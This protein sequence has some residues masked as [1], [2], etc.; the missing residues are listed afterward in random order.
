MVVNASKKLDEKAPEIM[1]LEY[2]SETQ[3][4]MQNISRF[5]IM[6]RELHFLRLI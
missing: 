5:I 1:G 2:Q 6:I 3:L 4:I